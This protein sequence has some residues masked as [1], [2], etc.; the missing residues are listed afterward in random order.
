VTIGSGMNPVTKM[1]C[2]GSTIWC[3]CGSQVKV[4]GESGGMLELLQAI[5]LDADRVPKG[6]SSLAATEDSVWVALQGSSIIKLYSN[7]SFD[8]LYETDVAPEVSKILAGT[9]RFRFFTT[10][11]RMDF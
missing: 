4:Y 11:I 9:C 6:V 5:Q 1:L 7:S 2:V 8:C 10:G 3:A